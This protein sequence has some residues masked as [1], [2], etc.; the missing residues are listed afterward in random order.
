[1]LGQIFENTSFLKT[2]TPCSA[3][4]SRTILETRERSKTLGPRS[5]RIGWRPKELRGFKSV[6]SKLLEHKFFE[7]EFGSSLSYTP[8]H[9]GY[10]GNL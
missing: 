10:E 8:N 4:L 6:R 7:N 5:V 9:I 3:F 2:G 1:M